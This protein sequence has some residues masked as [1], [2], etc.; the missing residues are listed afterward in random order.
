MSG[1]IPSPGAAVRDHFYCALDIAPKRSSAVRA[2][3][4]WQR[5]FDDLDGRDWG[6]FVFKNLAIPSSSTLS[7][8]MKQFEEVLFVMGK[9]D[10]EVDKISRNSGRLGMKASD[11]V[12]L[13]AFVRMLRSTLVD[14]LLLCRI[15][16]ASLEN[17]K[18]SLP[19]F[20]SV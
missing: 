18:Q 6:E 16:L 7:L 3:N 19:A 15:G 17:A 12:A 14:I 20:R 4:F 1:D 9:V 10:A 2:Y 11:A 13:A 8:N 5:L